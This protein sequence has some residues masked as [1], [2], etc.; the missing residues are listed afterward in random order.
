MS[1]PV[2]AR[3]PALI[4][5]E[6]TGAETLHRAG[7]ATETRLL[8]FWRWSS[9][10]LMSNATRGVLA[11]WIVARALELPQ[12]VRVEWDAFDLLTPKGIS[13]EVKSC[14][15]LQSWAQNKLSAIR[16]D[17]RPT[18]LESARGEPVRRAQ[19][20][21]FCVLHRRE[22]ATV[23]P[24]DLEQWEFYI[25]PTTVLNEKLGAQKSLGLAKLLSL[26]PLR[27]SFDGI[28]AGVARLASNSGATFIHP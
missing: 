7:Q 20:Y 19:I 16:F 28:A 23:D 12:S 21:V 3:W 13:I 17:I 24:L 8:D 6:K 11:E 22:Q 15:Y 1:E 2:E 14:A 9:S 26:A 25:L 10:D 18:Q 5:A 4:I 27:V